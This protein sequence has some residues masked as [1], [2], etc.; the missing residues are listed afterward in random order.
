MINQDTELLENTLT[1]L[2]DVLEADSTI[3]IAE[4]RQAPREHPKYYDPFTRETSWCSGACMMVRREAA[5]QVGGFDPT[6][7]MY[8]EDVDLSWRMWRHG[9][10]CVYVAEAVVRHFTE[11]LD[12]FRNQKKPHFYRVRNGAIMRATYGTAGETVRHFLRIAGT[13]LFSPNPLWHRWGS[14]MA[15]FAGLYHL[16]FA[17]K[18][19]WQLRHLPRHR[20]IFFNGSEYGRHLKD[21]AVVDP[22][23]WIPKHRLDRVVVPFEEIQAK[24]L[25]ESRRRAW[26]EVETT[27]AVG[28]E[29]KLAFLTWNSEFSIETT[30]PPNAILHGA[31]GQPWQSGDAEGLFSVEVDAKPIF[32]ATVSRG[33]PDQSG[34]IPFSVALPATTTPKPSRITMRHMGANA[35]CWGYWTDLNIVQK[36]ADLAGDRLSGLQISIIVPTFNRADGVASVLQRLIAQDMNSVHYEILVVDNNSTDATQEVLATFSEHPNFARSSAGKPERRRPATSAWRTRA[37]S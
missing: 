34:W 25:D 9:W 14:T 2:I 18:K 35:N 19:R 22:L 28:P 24:V 20:M 15:F 3:G 36:N 11:E 26:L 16:P 1:R 29:P 6:F 12:P 7:F 21:L 32:L 30:L 31:F 4:A 10:K 17:L 23:E 5:Q 37:A 27:E 33:R 13:A 8:A